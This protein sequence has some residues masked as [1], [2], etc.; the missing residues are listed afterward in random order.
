MSLV[1]LQQKEAGYI[2][3]YAGIAGHND[4]VIV[5]AS[6]SLS[7]LSEELLTRCDES[8]SFGQQKNGYGRILSARLS[9]SF[10]FIYPK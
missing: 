10:Y 4:S 7:L 1:S 6:L 5:E 2:D 3:F 8:L 9:E